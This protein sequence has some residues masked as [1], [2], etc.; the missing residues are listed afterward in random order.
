[1]DFCFVKPTTNSNNWTGGKNQNVTSNCIEINE[2]L[3]NLSGITNVLMAHNL[4]V[5]NCL[6]TDYFHVVPK[7][8]LYTRDYSGWMC[9]KESIF[10]LSS[11]N[12]TQNTGTIVYVL[13]KIMPYRCFGRD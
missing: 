3:E 7:N 9:L 13:K 2:I 11:Y 6:K 1:M 10:S 8:Y 4:S 5:N 12:W